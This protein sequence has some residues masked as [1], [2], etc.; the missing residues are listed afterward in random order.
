MVS[1]T[2]QVSIQ[3]TENTSMYLPLHLL[4]LIKPL[5]HLYTVCNL[6]NA[7]EAKKIRR[8]KFI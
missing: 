4:L 2:I 6:E 5:L 8:K 7:I 1:I 3:V